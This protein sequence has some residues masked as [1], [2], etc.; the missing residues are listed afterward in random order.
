MIF[1]D[2]IIKNKYVHQCQNVTN[3]SLI[4]G[5]IKGNKTKTVEFKKILFVIFLLQ[6]HYK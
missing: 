4:Q 5:I 1:D 2:R 6:I 3:L